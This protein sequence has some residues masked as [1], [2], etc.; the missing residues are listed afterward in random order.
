M[1]ILLS[2]LR[3]CLFRFGLAPQLVLASLLIMV[4]AVTAVEAWTL[5]ASRL[6]L[7]DAAHRQLGT[8]VVLL[9][10]LLS[11]LGEKWTLHDGR[12]SL[13]GHVL[14]DREDIVD[15]L[16]HTGGGTATLF[17][18][19]VRI[20]TN[21]IKPDGRRA[22]GTRLAPGPVHDAIF[23]RGE[24]YQGIAMILGRAHLAI[25]EPLRDGSGH[26]IG[27]LFVGMPLIE[28]YAPITRLVRTAI[29]GTVLLSILAALANWLALRLALRPL[30]RLAATTRSLAEGNLATVVPGTGRRDQLGDLG[31]ALVALRDGAAASLGLQLVAEEE[32]AA[33]EVSRIEGMRRLA[34]EIED[35]AASAVDQVAAGMERVSTAADDMVRSA[36]AVGRDSEEVSNEARQMLDQSLVIADTVQELSTTMGAIAAQ[37]GSA[38]AA[39]RHAV[40]ESQASSSAIQALSQTVARI[41]DITRLVADIASR[42][43]LLAL[44]ATIEAARAGEA[45][46][47][48]AVVASEVKSLASQTAKATDEI[49]GQVRMIHV[50]MNDAVRQVGGISTIVA[51]VDRIAA[52]ILDAI[53]RQSSAAIDIA[54]A[55]TATAEGTRT[56]SDRLSIVSRETILSKTRAADVLDQAGKTRHAVSTLRNDLVRAI[57]ASAPELNRRGD[58]RLPMQQAARLTGDGLPDGATEVE[59]LDISASGALLCIPAHLRPR[60]RLALA[61]PGLLSGSVAAEIVGQAA[62]QLRVRFV[63]DG[64]T[65]GQLQRALDQNVHRSVPAAA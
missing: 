36:A 30:L 13:G 15:A 60:G 24:T 32:R 21:I 12:L 4:F 48:F 45:G 58:T 33:S 51:D 11:P 28:L 2:L 5:R 29:A 65:R 57:R 63:L 61:L 26:I 42:T 43:N 27:I 56:M 52:A 34:R 39:T 62:D 19:D 44:N 3:R 47:G 8:N 50:A 53:E 1:P 22:L 38:S 9:K 54:R 25:Y 55:V 23:L 20:A 49:N 18:G 64:S 37:V 59:L 46:R 10:E 41:S 6:A 16:R 31:R 40:S 17:A 35:E 14:N 7:T